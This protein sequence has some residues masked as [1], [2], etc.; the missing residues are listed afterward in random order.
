MNCPLCKSRKGFKF[1]EHLYSYEMKT[2]YKI[3]K[4][5]NCGIEFS[6]PMKS[7]PPSNYEKIEWYGER[8]EFHEALKFLK[9]KGVRILDIGCGEG[10]FLNLAKGEGFEVV[11][12]DF[13]KEAIKRAKKKFGLERVYPFTLEEFIENFPDEKFD[14]ICAFQV[15]EHLEN[16]LDFVLK[17]KKILKENGFFVFS[18]PNPER[19]RS[20][21]KGIREEWDFPPHH[22]T[23]WNNKSIHFLL[24]RTGFEI[25]LRKDKD[26]FASVLDTLMQKIHF[27]LTK[28]ISEKYRK[29]DFE[30]THINIEGKMNKIIKIKQFLFSPFAFIFY[31]PLKLLNIKGRDLL[32]IAQNK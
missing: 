7:A 19:L 4:C 17:L 5:K 26:L 12:I 13:N 32:I 20:R 28:K 27:N 16:P 6:E 3:F 31:F 25:L 1:I 29:K 22:L 9:G 23:R 15:I 2:E 24:K 30:N 11:G 14:V 10:H 18:I 21:V 8:W